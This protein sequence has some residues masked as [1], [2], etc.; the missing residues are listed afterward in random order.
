MPK[1]EMLWLSFEEGNLKDSSG[2]DFEAGV[3]SGGEDSH[4]ASLVQE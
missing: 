3:D 1:V 4:I 2:S